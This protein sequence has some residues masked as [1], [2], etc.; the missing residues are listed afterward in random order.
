MELLLKDVQERLK[1]ADEEFLSYD[2]DIKHITQILKD[3]EIEF[4]PDFKLV[5][6]AH[7]VSLMKRLKEDIP[8]NCGEDCPEEEVEIRAIKVAEK[9]IEPLA[10][11]YVRD[12]NRMEI[13]LAG[14]QLQLAI[15]MQKQE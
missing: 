6:Y 5:F 10:K 13:I 4:Q 1:M 14:I 9:L 8:L 2:A 7:M 11:K 12:L 3:E 15:E